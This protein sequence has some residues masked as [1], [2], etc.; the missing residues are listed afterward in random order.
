MN[1][2]SRIRPWIFGLLSLGL[3]GPA[4]TLAQPAWP[5]KAIRI[6]VPF[7]PG[8][9]T[10]LSARSLAV[11]LSEQ[12]A[13]QV[14]VENKG[15]AG[16]TLG[17]DVVAKSAPDGH[18][19]LLTDNSFVM[20]AGL[21]ARLP[22]DPQKDFAQISQLAESPSIMVA[23]LELPAKST[24][25]LVELARAKPG[26][27]N[28]G[29]GGQ[30]SS[31]HLATELFMSVTS[32]KM[33]HI[34]FKG[35]AASI[36]EVMAGRIDIS[37]ASLASGMPHVRSGRVQGLGVTG[38]ERSPLLPTVPTF[39]EAGFG[40]YNMSYWWGVAAP[41]GTPAAV[42]TRLNLE[43]AKAAEKARL[44][45]SFVAQGARAVT[46]SQ[47]EANKRVE[48]EI[49]VWKTIIQKTNLKIE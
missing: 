49:Q 10:D 9:F 46:S 34:P 22:Y 19:L 45:D 2:H 39:A 13:Q 31:A 41:S 1:S 20:S 11:E 15:G 4:L 7:A 27:L 38:K 44:R 32:T 26:E 17:A 25:K 29:S 40:D 37:I 21:Y 6:I 18:T 30:G 16:G 8:S 24:A 33:S 42:L 43:I 48:D 14:F 47:I 36:A 5:S 3:A 35:V 12:L 23:R 28:F